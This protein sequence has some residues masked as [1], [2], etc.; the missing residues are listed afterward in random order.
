M[1]HISAAESE[2]EGRSIKKILHLLKHLIFFAPFLT[3]YYYAFN[4]QTFC[5]A[6]RLPFFPPPPLPSLHSLQ[7]LPGSLAVAKPKPKPKAIAPAPASFML[8]APSVSSAFTHTPMCPLPTLA[9]C[10]FLSSAT[11][12]CQP[13]GNAAPSASAAAKTNCSF[14]LCCNPKLLLLI[15]SLLSPSRFLTLSLSLTLAL[16][17][18][19]SCSCN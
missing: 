19:L 3:F 12:L 14:W 7:L 9:G 17:V 11:P 2:R 16:Q 13:V 6:F 4:V 1:Q 8:L 10:L 15:I 5:Y 18:C